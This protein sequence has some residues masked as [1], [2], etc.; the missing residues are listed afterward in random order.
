VT[1]VT[2]RKKYLHQLITVAAIMLCIHHQKS[3]ALHKFV[4]KQQ[5][6]LRKSNGSFLNCKTTVQEGM[7]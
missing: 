3:G 2:G 4:M 5:F 1:A 6:L 7:L